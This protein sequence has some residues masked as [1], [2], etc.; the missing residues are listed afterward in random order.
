MLKASSPF[1]KSIHSLNPDIAQKFKAKIFFETQ[2]KLLAKSS[3]KN[4]KAS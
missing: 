4:P 1:P 3:F 2:G